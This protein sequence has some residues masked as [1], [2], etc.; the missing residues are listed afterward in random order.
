[1]EFPLDLNHCPI[2]AI[3]SLPG[4]G[5]KRAVRLFRRRPYRSMDEVAKALD[6]PSLVHEMAPY[7]VLR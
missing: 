4:I 2:A 6:E 1:V 3:E 5:N 7:L